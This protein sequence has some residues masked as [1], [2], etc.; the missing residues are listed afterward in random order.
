MSSKKPKKKKDSD[1][2]TIAVSR[3]TTAKL[4]EMRRGFED[5]DDV[6]TRLLNSQADV[7]T[8]FVL[9]DNELPQLHTCIFQLGEDANSL[10]VFNGTS[11]IATTLTEVN[12]LMKQPKPNFTL[13]KDEVEQYILNRK[14]RGSP[15]LE[16]KFF[17][18]V[19]KFLENQPSAEPERV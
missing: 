18:R 6:L 2:T 15:E 9:I 10:F 7:Y 17:E 19:N 14:D 5:Y 1:S 13:M 16:K 3:K 11:I 12:K 8:E 4:N